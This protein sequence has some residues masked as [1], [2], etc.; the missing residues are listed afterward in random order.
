M[1]RSQAARL[2]PAASRSSA[3]KARSRSKPMGGC[4]SPRPAFPC[5]MPWSRISRRNP[6]HDVNHHHALALFSLSMISAQTR[7][8][9]V[10][11]ENR[12]PLFRFMLEFSGTK[13]LW[14]ARDRH[15]AAGRNA[16]DREAALVAPVGTEA[17]QPVDAGKAGR[18]GQRVGRIAL[19]GLRFRKRRDKSDRIVG[20]RRGSH[21]LGTEPGTIAAGEGA[22]A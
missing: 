5:S 12:F 13:A 6:E 1:P 19:A 10:A 7:S 16:H 4:A 22:E 2:T 8:A 18:I 9:F 3:R 14:R 11:R 20:Q 21:R 17:K 15:A